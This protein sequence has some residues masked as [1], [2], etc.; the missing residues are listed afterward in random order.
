MSFGKRILSLSFACICIPLSLTGCANDLRESSEIIDPSASQS[1]SDWEEMR[2]TVVLE[3]DRIRFALDAVSTHFTVC[4]KRTGQVY[5]S[6]PAKSIPFGAEEIAARARSELTLHYYEEQSDVNY[7]YSTADSVD[8]GNYSVRSD[9]TAV[10][11]YY[12]FGSMDTVLPLVLDEESFRTV[13]EAIQNG[14]IRRRMERYYTLY[15]KKDPPEDFADK[16]SAYPILENTALYILSDNLTSNEKTDISTYLTDS[17]YTNAQ[18]EAMLKGLKMDLSDSTE[19]TAGF[20]VPVEYTL[21]DDGFSASILM[22]LIEEKSTVHK[23]Q[24]IDF[25]E[26]FFATQDSGGYYFIPDGSGS[27]VDFGTGEEMASLPFYG[28]DYT[29]NHTA[30]DRIE[31]NLSLPVFGASMRV[32]GM[33]AIIEQAAE[34]AQLNL[35]ASS[36]ADPVNHI[37]ASFAV[38][39][40]DVTDYGASMSIPIYNLFSAERITASP[41]IRFVLLPEGQ[42]EYTHMA[43]AYQ[44]YLQDNGTL[45]KQESAAMPV[46]LDY[47]CMITEQKSFLGIPYVQETVLS[48][49]SGIMRSVSALQEAGLNHIIVRLYGYTS[50]GY[51]HPAYTRYTLSKKVGSQEEL[52]QLSRQLN[53][54]GGQ[55]YLDADMQFAYRRGNGFSPSKD[56]ARYLNRIVVYRGQHDIVTRKYTDQLRRYFISPIRYPAYTAAFRN[57]LT[58]TFGSAACPG[59]SYGSTGMRLGGDYTKTRDI[60]RTESVRYAIAALRSAKSEGFDLAF[61]NGNA[62][63]LPY[64]SHLLQVPDTD[65]ARDSESR[66]VPFYQMVIHGSISYA[67]TPYTVSTDSTRSMLN[68]AAL[69]AAPYAV[70]ITESDSSIANTQ[71]ESLWYSMQDT[72]QLPRFIE[73]AK[74]LQSLEAKNGAA[75]LVGYTYAAPQVT[76]STYANSIKVYVNYGNQAITVDG[77]TVPPYDF[78]VA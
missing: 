71:F 35:T 20:V 51:E 31:K 41:K 72:V 29:E 62:Y 60:D 26:Y 2:E 73:I 49:L 12:R 63:V 58:E 59:L 53:A 33:L 15:S 17:G 44:A 21:Q 74:R 43:A 4:D 28:S 25:L 39:K 10:R 45:T 42:N 23:L 34:V 70:F 24:K 27:L 19:E 77:I 1:D 64:A 9:G 36:A 40:I 7:M 52:E 57:S 46:Y 30:L 55:L 76:C 48:T 65:S 67:G 22:D 32:G 37:Y 56:A 8:A 68:S 38:R 66:A 5:S 69:G 54:C 61:D 50:A 13:C 6:V 47:V 3:N 75:A 16:L 18:Y 14:A 78:A 11:V